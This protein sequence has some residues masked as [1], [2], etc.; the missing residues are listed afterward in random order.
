M[1]KG[2]I[3]S[4]QKDTEGSLKKMNEWEKGGEKIH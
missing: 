3:I 4:P 2:K 1:M